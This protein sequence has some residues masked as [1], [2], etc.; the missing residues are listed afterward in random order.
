VPA[1]A[2]VA[3]KVQAECAEIS[4]PAS[5]IDW[6]GYSSGAPDQIAR[7]SEKKLGVHNSAASW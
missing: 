5:M 6:H 4:S 7:L 2:V 1:K 3:G